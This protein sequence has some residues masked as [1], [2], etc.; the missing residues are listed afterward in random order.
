MTKISRN[1]RTIREGISAGVSLRRERGTRRFAT[2]PKRDLFL[3]GSLVVGVLFFD[4]VIGLVFALVTQSLYVGRG[5]SGWVGPGIAI[6]LVL[7][8][9][10]I[11]AIGSSLARSRAS[12]EG[13]VNDSA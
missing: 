6:A 10:C 7:C 9:S 13:S 4:C 3:L 11:L 5:H 2:P 1:A 8:Q 12:H